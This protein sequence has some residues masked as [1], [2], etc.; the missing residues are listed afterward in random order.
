MMSWADDRERIFGRGGAA[1]AGCR[2]DLI[3]IGG[4]ITGAGLLREASALGYRTLLLEQRDFAFG[5]SSRSGKL[6]HGGLRYLKQGQFGVTWHSVRERERLCRDEPDLVKRHDVLLAVGR[7]DPSGRAA[8]ALGL[9]LYDLMGKTVGRRRGGGPVRVRVTARGRVTA[10][11]TAT[12]F[13]AH[14]YLGKDELSALLPQMRRDGLVGGFRYGDA[15]TDDAA[16]VLRVLRQGLAIG[17]KAAA[18]TPR[19]ATATAVSTALNYA[20]VVRLSDKGVAVRD[21]LTGRSAEVRAKVVINATGPWADGVR[22]KF[23]RP[24]FPRLRPLRGSHLVFAA[25]RFPL[26]WAVN[27]WHPSD[28]RPLYAFPWQGAIVVG[29]TDLDHDRPLAEEARI[30]PREVDYLLSA[31]RAYFPAIDLAEGDLVSTFAGV[32]PVVGTG[33]KDPWRESRE[34][35]VWNEDGLIT[36]T[37]GKLTTF[38]L[39][40]RDALRV[41]RPALGEPSYAGSTS[42]TGPAAGA[43]DPVGPA[44]PIDPT[45]AETDETQQLCYAV[46]HLDDLMLRRTRLGLL[47]TAG[48]R[49]L[50]PQIRSRFQATLGWDDRRWEDEERRYLAIWKAYYSP[51]SL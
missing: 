42:R 35:V 41:A 50:L 6:V 39:L 26:A 14:R 18:A 25:D 28:G 46:H 23:R 10:G 4:G 8:L 40:A 19:P 44:D 27:L 47:Q 30:S 2:W 36:V 17:A 1:E 11:A 45:S 32:R 43:A 51:S 48:G 12:D 49:H 3:V 20:Q 15:Q 37:G 13:Q 31:L 22:A 21:E 24:L 9:A 29:T 5:A 34:H 33:K 7:G 16:L 38:R